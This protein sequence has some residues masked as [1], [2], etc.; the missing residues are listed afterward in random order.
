[1]DFSLIWWSIVCRSIKKLYNFL[2]L[3]DSMSKY[4]AVL[5]LRKESLEYV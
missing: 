1:M 5:L 4:L 3:F 2:I